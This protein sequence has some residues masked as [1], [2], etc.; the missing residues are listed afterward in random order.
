MVDVAVGGACPDTFE[1][2]I[3]GF[4]RDCEFCG[5]Y[6][7]DKCGRWEEATFFLVS[8]ELG[9]MLH[10]CEAM[11]ISPVEPRSYY[12]KFKV[13]FYFFGCKIVC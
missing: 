6:V 9:A 2:T 8:S 3:D 12:K 10:L 4:E 11:F 13:F 7:I 1:C 5:L